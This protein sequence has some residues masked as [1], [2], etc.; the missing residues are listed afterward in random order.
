M[1]HIDNNTRFM[2]FHLLYMYFNRKR[3][4]YVNSQRLKILVLIEEK[5]IIHHCYYNLLVKNTL[6][7]DT[8]YLMNKLMCTHYNFNDPFHHRHTDLYY[9]FVIWTEP[10]TNQTSPLLSTTYT[11]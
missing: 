10:S 4:L 1:K 11:S 8:I 3:K 6:I 9:E 7:H 2:R 5:R